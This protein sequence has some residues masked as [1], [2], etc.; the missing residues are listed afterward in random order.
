M[1]RPAFRA[2]NREKSSEGLEENSNPW[3]IIFYIRE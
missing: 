2:H 3:N 1:I